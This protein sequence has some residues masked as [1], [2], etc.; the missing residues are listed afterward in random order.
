[1]VTNAEIESKPWK[2]LCGRCGRFN[3]DWIVGNYC[4]NCREAYD[5]E[6]EEMVSNQ[7]KDV[8]TFWE[9]AHKLGY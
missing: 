1:M 2:Y 5:R 7:K 3:P 9:R 8:E 4:P 6:H